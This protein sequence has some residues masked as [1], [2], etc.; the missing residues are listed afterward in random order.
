MTLQNFEKARQ[1]MVL[2]QLQPSGIVSENVMAAYQ[3]IPREMF[4]PNAL[5]G[6]SY[7]DDD[8]Q[9]GGGRVLMEPLL[10]GLMTQHAAL[11][12]GDK[13]L[14]IGGGT[15]YS[16]AILA[17]LTGAVIALEQ[18]EK[19][20]QEADGHWNSLG[21]AGKVTAIVGDHGE[22]YMTGAP[23]KAIILNGAMAEVPMAL[24]SQLAPD[25]ALYGMLMPP[26][27]GL[28]KVVAIRRDE[29]GRIG[30]T[31][32]GEGMTAYVPGFTPVKS[33]VF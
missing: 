20:L 31:I 12:M 32:L 10:H 1:N 22:G 16:A 7:M 19:L 8:I 28:G 15:G 3:T 13:C 23:Y 11:K 17:L 21:L 29:A 25:G 18:E 33:F 9:L 2:S 30:Q 6:V 5:R 27:S 14:D 24:L 4:V 26:D